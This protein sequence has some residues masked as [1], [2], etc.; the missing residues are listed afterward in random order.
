MA[1]AAEHKRQ[2]SGVSLHVK[3]IKHGKETVE[4]DACGNGAKREKA[5]VHGGFRTCTDVE[6]GC[7]TTLRNERGR[8]AVCE[9]DV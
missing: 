8:M 3:T 5:N 9:R 4:A 1:T 6:S 7:G 2:K